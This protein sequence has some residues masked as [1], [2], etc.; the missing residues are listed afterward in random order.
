MTPQQQK[1]ELSKAYVHAVAARCG[2]AVGSWSQDQSCI[3]VTIA[4]AGILGSG[5]LADPK[6]DLQL[7]CTSDSY[8]VKED[9]VA[10]SLERAHYEKLRARASTP[11]I[12]VVLVLPSQ[13]REWVEH[14]P[15][16]LIVRRCAFWCSPDAWPAIDTGSKLVHLP[17]ANVFSP[18]WLSEAMERISRGEKP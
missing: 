13:E 15:E 7:K 3:D 2:F 9:H 8:A 12:L 14:T 1:E 10:W 6:L 17:L 18:R 5:T 16:S 11:K 4:A